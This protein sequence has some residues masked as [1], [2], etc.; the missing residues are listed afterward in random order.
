M[1]DI[2]IKI[3]QATF[4]DIGTFTHLIKDYLAFYRRDIDINEITAFISKRL[5]NNKF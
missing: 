2:P 1:S 3:Q 4:K 5:E